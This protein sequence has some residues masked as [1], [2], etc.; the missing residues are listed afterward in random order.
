MFCGFSVL[1]PNFCHVQS[2]LF[3]AV[4][5]Q[6]VV[7]HSI[8]N[9]IVKIY[10]GLSTISPESL[11]SIKIFGFSVGW[12]V[13]YSFHIGFPSHSVCV[14]QSSCLQTRHSFCCSLW[15]QAEFIILEFW[16][17]SFQGY[18]LKQYQFLMAGCFISSRPTC[19]CMWLLQCN[20]FDSDSNSFS[21]FSRVLLVCGYV[22]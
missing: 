19:S 6:F 15:N 13:S 9:E 16:A 7:T 22:L 17:F 20:E 4:H 14:I 3:G 5:G 8:R 10:F 18:R 12:A 1:Y 2:S 21:M 11:F